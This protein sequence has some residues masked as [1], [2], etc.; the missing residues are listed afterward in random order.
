MKKPIHAPPASAIKVGPLSGWN[1]AG[2]YD[3][4]SGRLRHRHG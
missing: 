4:F 1:C 2:F 3:Q